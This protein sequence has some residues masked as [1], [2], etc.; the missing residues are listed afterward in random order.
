[1]LSRLVSRS[2]VSK[3]L[4]VAVKPMGTRVAGVNAGSS[5]FARTVIQKANP[6]PIIDPEIVKQVDATHVKVHFTHPCNIIEITPTY[7]PAAD[8]TYG[9]KVDDDFEEMTPEKEAK[10][11]EIQNENTPEIYL[12]G[13]PTQSIGSIVKKWGVLPLIASSAII[14]LSKELVVIDAHFVHGVNFVI[15]TALAYT[16][17]GD[18]VYKMMLDEHRAEVKYQNDFGHLLVESQ[19]LLLRKMIAQVQIPAIIRDGVA[20]YNA[21]AKAMVSYRNLSLRQAA[22]DSIIKKLEAIER[23]EDEEKTSQ[24]EKIKEGAMAYVRQQIQKAPASKQQEWIENSIKFLSNPQAVDLPK[25]YDVQR[26]L[27]EYYTTKPWT[28]TSKK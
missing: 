9:M 20:E 24:A 18:S 23:R 8:P 26:L 3:G 28:K 15:W 10:M 17:V 25:Q 19:A 5:L 22:R 1:M 4:Y 27:D 7:T 12:D 13:R 16:A 2:V 21:A 11:N 6:P 14:A